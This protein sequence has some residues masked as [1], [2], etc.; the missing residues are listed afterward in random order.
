MAKRYARWQ[1]LQPQFVG[2]RV[3]A[4][5]FFSKEIKAISLN[6]L[7]KMGVLAKL[8]KELGIVEVEQA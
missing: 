4:P 3:H 5:Q 6:C 8:S 7:D 1:F 2:E